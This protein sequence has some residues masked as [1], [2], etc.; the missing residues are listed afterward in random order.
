MKDTFHLKTAHD[1]LFFSRKSLTH[2]SFCRVMLN[3]KF[4]SW[5]N[6]LQQLKKEKN[7]T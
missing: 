7:V 4:F 2:A 6:L 5:P 1:Q 3:K